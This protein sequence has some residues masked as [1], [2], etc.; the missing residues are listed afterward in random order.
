M[1]TIVFYAQFIASKSG[2]A[3][4]AYL[5]IERIT[6]SDGSRSARRHRLEPTASP[7]AGAGCYGY[8]LARAPT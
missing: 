7:W 5:D 2:L 4:Y 8:V 3:G 6:R 1:T